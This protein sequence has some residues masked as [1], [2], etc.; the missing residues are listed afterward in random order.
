MAQT[1]FNIDGPI[2]SWGFSKQMV[3]QM[4]AKAGANPV[5]VNISSLGGDVDHALAIHDSFVNHAN[6]D[7]RLSGFVASSA[8]IIASGAKN[9]VMNSTAFYLIHKVSG[10]I[11]E[12]GF[13]NEDEL[14]ELIDRFAREAQENKKI[15]LVIAQIYSKRTGKDVQDIVDLMKKETWLTAEEAKEWGFV[16]EIIEMTG[17]VNEI[18]DA[19]VAM[20]EAAGLPPIPRKHETPQNNDQVVETTAWSILNS[21]KNIL[22]SEKHSKMDRTKFKPL[23]NAVNVD[24]I[25]LDKDGGFYVNAAQ[26]DLINEAIAKAEK[27]ESER[28]AA[29]EAKK[30][31]EKAQQEAETARQNILNSLDE[32]DETVKS[33]ENADEKINAVKT[34]IAK[35]PGSG[36]TGNGGGDDN[37]DGVDWESINSLPHNKQADAEL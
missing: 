21:V 26:V 24:D 2:G 4:L 16:D 20:I 5:L 17:K 28:Q 9:V 8:T 31:A 32:I 36:P 18:S 25:E 12:F 10:W 1:V 35:V 7:A 30:A 33:A 6:I 13:K 27:A 15:D 34:R 29:V 37:Q 19:K 11:D 23:L 3:T 22:K 14:Q